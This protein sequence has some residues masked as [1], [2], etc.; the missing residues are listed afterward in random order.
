MSEQLQRKQ[1]LHRRL[2]VRAAHGGGLHRGEEGGSVCLAGLF[3]VC[4]YVSV[5]VLG[6]LVSVSVSVFCVCVFVLV[7]SVCVFVFVFCTR[8][9]SAGYVRVVDHVF[10][11]VLK[12]GTLPRLCIPVY[13]D[14]SFPVFCPCFSLCIVFI[15]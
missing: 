7:F 4:W 11:G 13:D 14:T 9:T 2:P 1:V 5:S 3:L 10:P 8:Y 12:A 6:C 15:W